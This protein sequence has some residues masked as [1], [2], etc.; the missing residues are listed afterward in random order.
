MICSHM[1]YFET[2]KC[3]PKHTYLEVALYSMTL[4]EVNVYKIIIHHS[5]QLFWNNSN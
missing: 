1:L 5:Y 2:I 4:S 3:D